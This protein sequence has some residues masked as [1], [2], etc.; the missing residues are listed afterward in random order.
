MGCSVTWKMFPYSDETMMSMTPASTPPYTRSKKLESP[1]TQRN[2]SSAELCQPLWALLSPRATWLWGPAQEEAFNTIK[3][4]LA[5]PATLA[6]YDHAIPTKISADAPAYGLGAVLLQQHADMWQ[7]VAFASRSMTDT[8]RWYSQIEEALALVWACEKFGDYVVGK[9]IALE[10]DHK[11]FVHLLN[12][13]NLDCLP[14][15]VWRFRILLM[16]FSS[17]TLSR[18]P[19]ATPDSTHLAE[20]SRTERF[21]ASAVSL[22]AASA[23]CLHKHRTAQ[24]ND[25]TCAEL[26]VLHRMALQGPA[27]LCGI[28]KRQLASIS[29]EASISLLIV[30]NSR[31][32]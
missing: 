30:V 23:D 22:H 26:I 31:E 4:E 1:S 27:S 14:P 32:N 6:L 21:A 20:D 25:P 2:T 28:H 17:D 8:E 24:H 5:N 12:K 16:R 15:R 13:T 29:N 9:D 11:Q 19:A 7:P 18:A 10:T 3:S